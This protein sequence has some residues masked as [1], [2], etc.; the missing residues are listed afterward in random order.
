[1]RARH[2]AYLYI[3]K[4]LSEGDETLDLLDYVLTGCAPAEEQ[5]AGFGRREPEKILANDL[6][7]PISLAVVEQTSR[8]IRS[9]ISRVLSSPIEAKSSLVEVRVHGPMSKGTCCG[10]TEALVGGGHV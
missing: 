8:P 1:M 5:S 3:L 6:D 7:I 2:S 4:L 10:A 9:R